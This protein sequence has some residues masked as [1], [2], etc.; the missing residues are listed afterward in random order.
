MGDSVAQRRRVVTIGQ[1][2]RLGKTQGLGHGA[3]PQQNRDSSH[4]PPIRFVPESAAEPS[5]HDPVQ[6]LAAPMWPGNGRAFSIGIKLWTAHNTASI[7]QQNVV[8]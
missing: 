1:Y 8:A 7:N 4:H 5:G 6:Y 3:T 2:D